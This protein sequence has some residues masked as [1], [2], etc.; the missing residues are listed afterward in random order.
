MPAE[1]VRQGVGDGDLMSRPVVT[2]TCPDCHRPGRKL[3]QA[4]KIWSHQP[5]GKD[6]SGGMVLPCK[7]SGKP[8]RPVRTVAP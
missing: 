3:T 1:R 6:F 4:G 2:V 5:W 7:G 8:G